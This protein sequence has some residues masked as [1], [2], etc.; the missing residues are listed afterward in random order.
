MLVKPHKY[1]YLILGVFLLTMLLI[2]TSVNTLALINSNSLNDSKLKELQIPNIL[3]CA[4]IVKGINHTVLTLE[5]WI[6]FGRSE[7][8]EVRQETW[9]KDITP[10][11][12]QLTKNFKQIPHTRDSPQLK[13]IKTLLDELAH[14]QKEIEG[15]VTKMVTGSKGKKL[16]YAKIQLDKKLPPIILELKALL[17]VLSNQQIITLNN[18]YRERINSAQRIRLI[19][20][21]GLIIALTLTLLIFNYIF[22]HI[23]NPV[24]NLIT[25]YEKIERK[26]GLVTYVND[27]KKD[28][29][30]NLTRSF[31]ELNNQLEEKK[32]ELIINQAQLSHENKM[33]S[34]GEMAANMAHEINTPMQTIMLIAQRVQRKLKKEVN[35]NDICSSMDTIEANVFNISEIIESLRTTSRDSKNDTFEK[36]TIKELISDVRV[37]TN[38]RFKINNI[39]FKVIYTKLPKDTEINCKRL[40]ISQVLI[41]IINNAFN[42]IE[43]L[44]D[45]WIHIEFSQRDNTLE[46]SITDSGSGIPEHMLGK[47]FTPLFTTNEIGRGTGLGLSIS[48][49]IILQHH[50]EIYVDPTCKN[51]RFIIHLPI[52]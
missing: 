19:V 23:I 31:I 15:V 51:T 35:I 20:W 21:V 12:S 28:Q 5:K 24:N 49:E 26:N 25:V 13:R 36:V 41:N 11:L 46:I 42:A 1:H 30:T 48:R 39:A 44:S 7:L 50:G 9:D 4:N 52:T 8:K 6:L 2:L 27:S 37:L 22:R 33:S 14:Q 29:L 16:D 10:A 17:N 34:L 47:I 40:Q 45:K 38:E 43:L 32:Q 18:V 3:A